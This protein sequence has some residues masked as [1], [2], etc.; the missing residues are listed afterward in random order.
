MVDKRVKIIKGTFFITF[1]QEQFHLKTELLH[2]FDNSLFVVVIFPLS[3][4]SNST[5]L[6]DPI[7]FIKDGFRL[8]DLLNQ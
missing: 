8:D 5:S 6:S 3:K 7:N 2:C 4:K 1:C